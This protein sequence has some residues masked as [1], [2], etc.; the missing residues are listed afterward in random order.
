MI[1][2]D[3]NVIRFWMSL[4]VFPTMFF[5]SW[6][7]SFCVWHENDPSWRSN[8]LFV[9]SYCARFLSLLSPFVSSFKSMHSYVWFEFTNRF[10]TC[11]NISLT[12]GFRM[13]VANEGV[14]IL[15]NPDAW[16]IKYTT[17]SSTSSD[18]SKDSCEESKPYRISL[19]VRSDIQLTEKVGSCFYPLFLHFSYILP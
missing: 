3:V 4:S 15:R 7:S 16:T 19:P 8:L 10:G 1:D 2:G 14:Y 11:G 6:S 5:S 18:D 17:S 12:P 13:M 9:S